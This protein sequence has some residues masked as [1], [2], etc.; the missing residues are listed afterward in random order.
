MLQVRDQSKQVRKLRHGSCGVVLDA[1]QTRPMSGGSGRA[2]VGCRC[3]PPP[4]LLRDAAAGVRHQEAR[5][6]N[7]DGGGEASP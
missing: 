2:L 6:A 7:E 3:H 1:N 5:A 4:L